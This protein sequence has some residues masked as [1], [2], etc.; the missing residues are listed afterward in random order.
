MNHKRRLERLEAIVN[1]KHSKT[2]NIIYRD[3]EK[4]YYLGKPWCGDAAL[5]EEELEA[6]REK[7]DTLLVIHYTEQWRDKE[8]G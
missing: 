2:F 6:I 3:D 7:S 5:T 8:D 1:G 4:N